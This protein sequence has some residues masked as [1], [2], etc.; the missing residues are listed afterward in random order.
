ME[1]RSTAERRKTLLLITDGKHEPPPTSKYYSADGYTSHEYLKVTSETQKAGWKIIVIGVGSPVAQEL[2]DDLSAEYA[3]TASDF[4]AE[5]LDSII[6][7][8]AGEITLTG[9]PVLSP[10]N[11]TGRSVLTLQIETGSFK[12]APVIQI[13]SIRLESSIINLDNLLIDPV[14][15]D[16]PDTGKTDVDIPLAFLSIPKAG[17]YDGDL[18]FSFTSK[19]SFQKTHTVQFRV[20]SFLQ[21]FPWLLPVAIS[22]GVLLLALLVF[23]FLRLKGDKKLSFRMI[24]ED[25]PLKKGKDIFIAR[26]GR[27]LFLKESMDI[28]DIDTQRTGKSIGKFTMDDQNLA[29]TRLKEDR[30]PEL[31]KDPKNVLGGSYLIRTESGKDFRVSFE[32]VD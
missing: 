27:D 29:L 16:L 17:T 7:D 19:E 12:S 3:E 26:K 21:N 28:L 14:S 20:N 25:K 32:R 4:T 30:F 22:V 24:V 18:F 5:G 2:A 1:K 23:L 11:R 6:P 15:F 10:V 13:D 8:L 31:D 9:P